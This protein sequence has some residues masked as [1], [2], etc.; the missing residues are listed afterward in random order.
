MCT[1]YYIHYTDQETEVERDKTIAE[2]HSYQV[3]KSGFEPRKPRYRVR[4]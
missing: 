1:I 4:D 2:C 3:M